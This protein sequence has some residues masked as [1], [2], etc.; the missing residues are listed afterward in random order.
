M[1]EPMEQ[2]SILLKEY[3]SLR[4]EVIARTAGLFTMA[5]VVVGIFAA[6]VSWKPLPEHLLSF[7][8]ITFALAGLMA[9]GLYLN[10]DMVSDLAQRIREIEAHIN[11]LAGT[12][13]LRYENEFGGGA[14]GYVLRKKVISRF[15]Y[16]VLPENT[17][18]HLSDILN[19]TLAVVRERHK[20]FR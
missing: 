3:D 12:S 20:R 5:T 19:K 10:A 4:S 13:L 18:A 9:V 1:I 2:I 8:V 16:P 15:P 11:A 14:R 7:F 6:I 17:D